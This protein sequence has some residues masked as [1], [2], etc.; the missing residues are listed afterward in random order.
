VKIRAHKL[1][2]VSN[3]GRVQIG[4]CSHTRKFNGRG[5]DSN[6]GS[7][8][9]P[10]NVYLVGSRRRECTQGTYLPLEFQVIKG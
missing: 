6:G 3:G 9:T 4:R 8:K 1:F 2:K 7:E 10:Q 5:V